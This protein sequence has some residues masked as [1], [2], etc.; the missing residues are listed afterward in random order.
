[1][2]LFYRSSFCEGA[3]GSFFSNR[4]LLLCASPRSPGESSQTVAR[5]GGCQHLGYVDDGLRLL[6]VRNWDVEKVV[7]FQIRRSDDTS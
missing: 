1:M 7:S 3:N 5:H 2:R 4:D 6:V